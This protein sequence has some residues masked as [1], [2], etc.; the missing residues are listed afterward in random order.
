MGVS[1]VLNLS[2]AIYT[3]VF[4]KTVYYYRQH[5]SHVF[6]C[7]IDFNKGFDNVD[8]WLLF[9]KLLDSNDSRLLRV[10]VQLACLLFG[11]ADN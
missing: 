11:T 1:T 6:T 5:G 8:Y 7:F 2:T 10:F 9:S 3:N 4:K